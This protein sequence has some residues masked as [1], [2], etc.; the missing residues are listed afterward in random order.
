MHKYFL[1]NNISQAGL[2]ELGP[3]YAECNSLAQADIAIVRSA[4]MHSMDTSNLLAVAR[5]GAGTNNIPKDRCAKEG[6]V[7][8][9]TPGANANAVKELML[10]GLLLSARDVVS[11]ID[12]VKSLD[13]SGEELPR[14]VE[15]GKS[16]F[17]GSEVLGKKAAIIGMGE[18]GS[19]LAN[20]LQAIGMQVSCYSPSFSNGRKPKKL[21]IYLES[22]DSAVEAID[23]ADY[24]FLALPLNDVTQKMVDSDFLLKMKDNSVLLNFSRTGLVDED[25]L[26]NALKTGK[27]KKYVTDFATQRVLGMENAICLPHMGASTKEATEN[28]AIMAVKQIKNYV[29]NGNIKNSVNYPDIDMDEKMGERLCVL[30]ESQEDLSFSIE[31]LFEQNNIDVISFRSILKEGRG[32]VLLDAN[33]IGDNI[34]NQISQMDSV[35]KVRLIK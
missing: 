22:K 18:I 24:V 21:K 12:W 32:V 17:K 7:V 16:Q 14:K 29:E 26:E 35:R 13:G 5:A 20:T 8:F 34:I 30:F 31:K 33:N 19:I 4:D 15:K 23:G 3:G 10:L 2:D 28:C 27:L 1:L 6:V 25:A 11:G 9:N